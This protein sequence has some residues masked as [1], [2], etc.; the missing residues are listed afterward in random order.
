MFLSSF[1][2][3]R[4]IK[5]IIFLF[6]LT[7]YLLLFHLHYIHGFLGFFRVGL[8]E[9]RAII[10]GLLEYQVFDRG[11]KKFIGNEVEKE[12]DKRDS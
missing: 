7:Y 4:W 2:T 8:I 12:G 5:N 6:T 3:L 10:E 9:Y 1:W 11:E